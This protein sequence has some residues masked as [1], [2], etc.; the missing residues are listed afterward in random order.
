MEEYL[1]THLRDLIGEELRPRDYELIEEKTRDNA[2]R[3]AALTRK[4]DRLKDLYIN[5]LITLEEYRQDRDRYTEEI[6]ALQADQD[7]EPKDRSA[8][9]AILSLDIEQIYKTLTPPEKR[10]F[11][12]GFVDY[13]TFYGWHDVKVYF[14]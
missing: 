2:D 11:W 9:E 6:D 8:L 10:R 14:L 5:E 1:L 13:I 12:R 4:R 7:A 3:I